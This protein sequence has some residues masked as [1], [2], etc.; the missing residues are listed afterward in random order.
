M[1]IMAQVPLVTV[2]KKPSHEMAPPVKKT[3]EPKT[4]KGAADE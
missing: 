1:G 3:C 2:C 4:K